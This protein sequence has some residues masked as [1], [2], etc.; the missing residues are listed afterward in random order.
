MT[1]SSISRSFLGDMLTVACAET[2]GSNLLIKDIYIKV[3]FE[4]I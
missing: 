1:G 4:I 2:V 3:P